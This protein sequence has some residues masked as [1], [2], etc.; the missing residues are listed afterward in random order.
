MKSILQLLV[1]IAF[2]VN[3]FAA[4]SKGQRPSKPAVKTKKKKAPQPFKWINKPTAKLPPPVSN[5]PP[6][7]VE[8]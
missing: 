4:T 5:T 8:S 1:A 6:I 7:A 2:T 3:G